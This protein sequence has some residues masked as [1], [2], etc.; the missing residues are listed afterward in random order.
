MICE[1]CAE[2]L[3]PSIRA[4]RLDLDSFLIMEPGFVFKIHFV[5][6]V[7]GVKEIDICEP[8]VVI[9]EADVVLLVINGLNRCRSPK[10]RIN[11]IANSA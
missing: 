8:A 10:V 6:F 1:F 4:K 9:S 2:K 11:F 5:G 3:S 7:F